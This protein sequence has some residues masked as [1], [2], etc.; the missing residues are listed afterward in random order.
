MEVLCTT[1]RAENMGTPVFL[2]ISKKKKQSS[3]LNECI[4]HFSLTQLIGVVLY[5]RC[6]T[7]SPT[8]TLSD[9]ATEHPGKVI[10]C[11]RRFEDVWDFN[12]C[13]KT[14]LRHIEQI[15]MPWDCK[16]S[17]VYWQLVAWGA[18]KA[19]LHLFTRLRGVRPSLSLLL[20]LIESL[21]HSLSPS[22]QALSYHCILVSIISLWRY[23]ATFSTNV[24]SA[25]CGLYRVD[26]VWMTIWYMMVRTRSRSIRIQTILQL[27]IRVSSGQI[28]FEIHAAVQIPQVLRGGIVVRTCA[29]FLPY[30][31]A[32][33]MISSAWIFCEVKYFLASKIFS[34]TTILTK[35][36]TSVTYSGS[37]GRFRIRFIYHCLTGCTQECIMMFSTKI[38]HLLGLIFRS[39]FC[40]VTSC[41]LFS[42]EAPSPRA[43]DQAG[44]M[45]P[46]PPDPHIKYLWNESVDI[47]DMAG[48]EQSDMLQL[49]IMLGIEVCTAWFS[50]VHLIHLFWKASK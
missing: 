37:I 3:Y 44:M 47:S 14:I 15:M 41:L 26:Y 27:K 2:R 10:R 46:A 12:S 34:A 11:A 24:F 18:A 30:A 48:I 13:G 29:F 19:K 38:Y 7:L 1:E 40:V 4:Q 50:R 28:G 45:P 32:T 23:Y 22:R 25:S 49:R 21:Y 16:R 9:N 43:L 8:R 42:S 20:P 31:C 5:L 33:T 39:S 36:L 17:F 6:L 35:R